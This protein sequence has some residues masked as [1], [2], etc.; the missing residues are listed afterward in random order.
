MALDLVRIKK[1]VST[2]VLKTVVIK[3]ILEDYKGW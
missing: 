3:I 2:D 1:Q